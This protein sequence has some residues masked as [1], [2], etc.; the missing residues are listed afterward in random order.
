MKGLIKSLKTG[1]KIFDLNKL[2]INLV[3]HEKNLEHVFLENLILNYFFCMFVFVIFL[4]MGEYRVGDIIINKS[5]FLVSILLYPFFY[6]LFIYFIYLIFALSAEFVDSKKNIRPLITI[7]FYTSLIYS[8]IVI[9]LVFIFTLNKIIGLL[10]LGLYLIYFLINMFCVISEVYRFS[11]HKSLIVLFI[12]LFILSFI[13]L[14]ISIFFPSLSA[15]LLNY[16]M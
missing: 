15:M 9:L 10:L 16:L 4:L 5:I 14:M 12:P 7:G 1:F 13:F 3:K 2:T 11:L 6:T 8:F